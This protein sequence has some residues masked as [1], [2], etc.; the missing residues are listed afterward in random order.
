MDANG[1]GIKSLAIVEAKNGD[2]VWK[3]TVNP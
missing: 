2:W 1:T 3:A